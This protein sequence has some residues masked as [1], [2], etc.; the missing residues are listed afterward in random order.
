MKRLVI[1]IVIVAL[2]ALLLM[3]AVAG[4]NP[5][6]GKGCHCHKANYGAAAAD[7]IHNAAMKSGGK[8]M[9]SALYDRFHGGD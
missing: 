9:N 4:A 5:E 7:G 3:P 6:A 2:F 1:A 8:T